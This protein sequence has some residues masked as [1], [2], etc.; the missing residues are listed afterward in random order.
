[1]LP[2]FYPV[3]PANWISG[4]VEPIQ[5]IHKCHV[6]KVAVGYTRIL[7]AAGE[8]NNQQHRVHYEPF[9]EGEANNVLRC[10]RFKMFLVDIRL[11]S[12]MN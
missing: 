12:P 8:A 5:F 7:P 3:P 6:G 2:G 10:K 11:Q 1:M 9:E 4:F